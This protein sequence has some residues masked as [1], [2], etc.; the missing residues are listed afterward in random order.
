MLTFVAFG[1]VKMEIWIF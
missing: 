1:I